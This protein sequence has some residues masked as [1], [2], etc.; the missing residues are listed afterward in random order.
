[1]FIPIAGLG[2]RLGQVNNL[3]AAAIAFEGLQ[4]ERPTD[5]QRK[6]PFG[7]GNIQGNLGIG[8][9]VTRID[10]L[11]WGEGESEGVRIRDLNKTG[12]SA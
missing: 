2:E 9:R 6:L 12:A 5:T 1:L 11:A 8:I 7:S 10:F 4:P 3:G